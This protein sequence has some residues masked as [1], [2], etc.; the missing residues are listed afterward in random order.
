MSGT[1][2]KE[3]RHNFVF[4]FDLTTASAD[5][6]KTFRCSYCGEWTADPETGPGILLVCP[7]RNRRNAQRRA[8][9]D[10]RC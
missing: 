4:A 2:P 10:R 1:P 9:K 5:G 6:C 8:R 7:A 3:V